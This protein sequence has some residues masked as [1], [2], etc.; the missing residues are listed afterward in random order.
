VEHVRTTHAKDLDCS[1][2]AAE[3]HCLRDQI[4]SDGPR[5]T[6]TLRE[7]KLGSNVIEHTQEH[8]ANWS[9][10]VKN[11]TTYGSSSLKLA[12]MK[13]GWISG[14]ELTVLKQKIT[15]FEEIAKRKAVNENSE[16]KA[17]E[18]YEP[19]SSASSL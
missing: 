4:A 13:C 16:N 5:D 18:V 17:D 2:G 1:I 6:I 8:V 11:V 7:S 10:L 14:S 19:L 15:E 3:L 12:G 9:K